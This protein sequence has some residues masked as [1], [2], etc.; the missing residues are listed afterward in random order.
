MTA[1][2]FSRRTLL[3]LAVENKLIVEVNCTV[4]VV[5]HGQADVTRWGGFGGPT[6][7]LA[8]VMERKYSNSFM[9]SQSNSNSGR[10]ESISVFI[11]TVFPQIFCSIFS[12]ELLQFHRHYF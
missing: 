5:G 9:A 7:E 3:I 6:F 10:V 1:A 8:F 4:W 11:M 2:G 12:E